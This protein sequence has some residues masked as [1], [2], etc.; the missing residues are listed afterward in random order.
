MKRAERIRAMVENRTVDRVGVSGW[1]H[2]PMVDR[3]VKDFCKATIDFTENNGWDFVKL[4]SNGH[5]FAEAY[6]ADIRWRNDPR[7]WSGDIREYPIK[8]ADDAAALKVADVDANPVFQREINIARN[9]C[10]HYKG[11]VPV[12]ATIFTPLTWLQEMTSST[13][14][15]PVLKMLAEEPGKVHKALHTLLETNLRFLDRLMDAGIDG[16]FLATQWAVRSLLTKAQMDE[17]C[18]PYDKALLN[19]IKDR[20]WFNMLHVH[21]CED[22]AFEEFAD[23]EGLQALNWENCT[24]IPD[25]SRLTSIRE[26]RNMYPDKVLI[27]G[28]DQH[29]DFVNADNDREAIKE[30]LRRRLLTG[31]EESGDGRFIFAPGCALPLDVDR[32]VFTLMGEV[33]EEEGMVK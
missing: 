32:Y 13:N 3:N 4:M 33:V 19:H 25:M 1:L 14:P 23:Y 16:I 26:V 12:L 17:F 24:K 5:Y 15:A 6:G 11:E 20:T 18:H 7:E 30:V 29:N 27:G 8:N 10:G 21:Y 9:V 28:I 31:M 22:L 2:M